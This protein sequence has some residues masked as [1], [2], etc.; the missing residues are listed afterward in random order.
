MTAYKSNTRIAT[1]LGALLCCSTAVHAGTTRVWVSQSFK[2]F[3]AGK[4]AGVLV[5]SAGR[6]VRGD[7]AKG[8]TLKGVSMVFASVEADGALYLGTGN[9]GE[10]WRLRGGKAKKLAALPGAVIVTCFAQG[11]KGVVYAGTL[12]EGKIFAIRTATGKV[13]QFAKL[14]ADHIWG[15]VYQ[16]KT[17]TLF[18]ATG[19]KGK[20]F[21][22]AAGGRVRLYWDSKEAHLQSISE[23][24][25]GA[26]YVGT[27]PKAIV[28]RLLG[29]RRARAL[30][31]F[32]G[33][34]IRALAGDAKHL[35]VAVNK[36]KPDRSSK[37]RFPSTFGKGTKI[38]AKGRPKRKLRLPRLGAKQGTG[39]LFVLDQHG[40]ATQLHALKKG[41]FTALE[42]VRGTLYAAEGTRG[43][44]YTVLPNRSVATAFDVKQRQVLSLALG[45]RLRAFGTGDGAAVYRLGA[46]AATYTSVAYDSTNVS[47]FGTASWRSSGR[48]TMHTRSGN[49]AVPD[50]GW[51]RWQPVAG[52]RPLGGLQRG[53][54][55]S[56]PARYVQYR[57]TWPGATRAVV[58]HVRLHFTPTNR[59]P[60]W[61][62][63]KVGSLSTGKTPVQ[64]AVWIT[65]TT[66][67][68]P[69]V[70]VIKWKVSDPDGDPI[71]YRVYYRAVGDVKWKQIGDKPVT[72]KSLKWKTDSLPDGWYEIRVAAADD[73]SN[74]SARAYVRPRTSPPVLVDHNKPD[75]VG[76]RVAYPFVAG[77]AR[78]SY[79]RI[80]GIAFSIDGKNWKQVDAADGNFD[81]EAERFNARLP[82]L[83]PG[84][85]S[86]LVRAYDAAGNAQVVRRA[87]RVK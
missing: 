70:L 28:Y 78:D 12:P 55:R 56:P 59:A 75:L 52:G 24:P 47:R 85:Y 79:S 50:K 61:K 18:A 20:L 29:P 51:S 80:T 40:S 43:R 82:K 74:S 76:L 60:Q 21:A 5:T 45:G 36:I 30:H 6:L 77:L 37:L 41:Y 14:K 73:K 9:K 26:I 71:S 3:D 11:P 1:L 44:V 15:L 49:T 8:Q 31:D 25:G 81:Q 32:S 42:L 58:N 35:Y 4:G 64:K 83:K 87:L 19:P 7:A 67:A 48:V 2:D 69:K 10:V 34:E 86:L 46:G 39:G 23:G 27:A 53:L 72:K 63:L 33:N 84:V 54:V 38:K 22:V 13:S 65:K 68:A 16:R 57:L 17:R 66:T 62:S